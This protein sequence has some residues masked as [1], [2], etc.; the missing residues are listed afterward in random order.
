MEKLWIKEGYSNVPLTFLGFVIHVFPVRRRLKPKVQSTLA[1]LSLLYHY[2][3][4][5]V[6]CKR[7]W[8]EADSRTANRTD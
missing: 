3:T 6:Y 2:K 1:N 8:K 7:F 5:K 4:C